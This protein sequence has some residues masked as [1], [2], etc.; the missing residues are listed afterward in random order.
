MKI[1]YFSRRC[2]SWLGV[3]AYSSLPYM[4]DS[5]IFDMVNIYENRNRII[6]KFSLSFGH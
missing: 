3:P 4:H 2:P 5:Y 1:S 6:Y